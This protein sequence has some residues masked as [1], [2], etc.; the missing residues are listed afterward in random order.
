MQILVQVCISQMQP[1][2]PV[3][4]GIQGVQW[5]I[6]YYMLNQVHIKRHAVFDFP[7]C[8]RKFIFKSD[9]SFSYHFHRCILQWKGQHFKLQLFTQVIRTFA[10]K[11]ERKS[12]SKV[13][14][15]R[16][17]EQLTLS[18]TDG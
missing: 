10:T 7:A 15:N 4:R 8:H 3:A 6:N 17:T 1:L 14:L 5:V 11:L 18:R 13:N 2:V 16:N 12:C 9:S